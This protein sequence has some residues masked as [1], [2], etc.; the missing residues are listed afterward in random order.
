MIGRDMRSPRSVAAALI[1]LLGVPLALIAAIAFGDGAEN[2]IHMTLAASFLLLAFAVFDFRLP[3]WINL[4]ACA[5]TGALATIFLLQGAGDLTHSASLQHLAYQVLGQRVEKV[6]GYVFLCWC[7]AMLLADSTGKTKI[8]G[9]V[10]LV[11]IFFIE[12]Y[13]IVM[14]Y[15]GG[16]APAVLKLFYLPLF[17]WLLLEGKQRRGPVLVD[18]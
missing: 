4:A 13:T 14:A 6:L 10:V 18:R 12:I 17:I 15:G 11:A 2:V 3:T 1:L 7:V 16:E 8:L 9:V 5:T